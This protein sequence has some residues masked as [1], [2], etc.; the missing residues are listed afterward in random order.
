MKERFS[1]KSTWLGIGAI[2]CALFRAIFFNDFNGVPEAVT[3]G[4]GLVAT[5]A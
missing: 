1:Q 2:G 4:L 5:N 3:M